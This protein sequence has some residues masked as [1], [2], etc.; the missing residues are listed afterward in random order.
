MF[1]VGFFVECMVWL[2]L[3]RGPWLEGPYPLT[4]Y[5]EPVLA[6]DLLFAFNFDLE[7]LPGV[8]LRPFVP[9]SGVRIIGWCSLGHG[10]L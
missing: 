2:T 6:F 10:S 9:T 5:V 8:V 1:E 3:L 7:E 4:P